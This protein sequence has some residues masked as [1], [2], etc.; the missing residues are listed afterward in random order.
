M[1]AARRLCAVMSPRARGDTVRGYPRDQVAR[2]VS[3]HAREMDFDDKFVSSKLRCSHAPRE[4]EGMHAGL[5]EGMHATV[6]RA[7]RG[8]HQGGLVAQRRCPPD[9]RA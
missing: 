1:G 9:A 4:V 7:P 2:H 6:R 5:D 3:T 8:G